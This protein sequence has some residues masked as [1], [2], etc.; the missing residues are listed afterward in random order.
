MANN[1]DDQ[2][3]ID[4]SEEY[5]RSYD[6]RYIAEIRHRGLGTYRVLKDKDQWILQN[7]IQTQ[8]DKWDSVWEKMQVNLKSQRD[9]EFNIHTA[10]EKTQDAKQKLQEIEDILIH[11]LDIDDTV[12]W[13]LLKDKKKLDLIDQWYPYEIKE[14][15]IEYPEAFRILAAYLENEKRDLFIQT[16]LLI[17]PGYKFRVARGLITNFHQP[18]STLL[19]LVAAALGNNWRWVYD[20]ALKH[21]YRFLSYGDGNLIFFDQG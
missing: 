18:G 2:H 13:D 5:T 3:N 20:H 15:G 7:K 21:N 12:N 8:F 9:K 1:F 16:K 17:A 11:T 4:I 10:D 19:L 14:P 6:T